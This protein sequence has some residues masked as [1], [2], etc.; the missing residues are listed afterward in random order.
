MTEFAADG[1]AAGGAAAGAAGR[2]RTRRR[3]ARFNRQVANRVVGPVL[4]RMPGFGAVLH[5]GRRSGRQYR[6]PVKLFRR[7]DGYLVSLP[8]GQDSDWVK[9]VLA[10]GG[11][12]LVTRG[13]Q[14]E[15]VDPQVYV[16]LEQQSIPAPIRAVLKRV[17]AVEFLALEPAGPRRPH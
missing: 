8:Y 16:D 13:R 4:T 6:T 7:G 9:N 12:H 17:G 3:L 2:T 10:A 5:R 11:C 15:L 1:S 14:L